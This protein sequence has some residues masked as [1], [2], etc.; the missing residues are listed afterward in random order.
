MDLTDLERSI[1]A[2]EKQWW[3]F[4]GGKESAIRELG[5][6]VTRY[7]QLLVRLVYTERAIAAD[8]ITCRRLREHLERRRAC[9]LA[10]HV[11]G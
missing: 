9:A 11:A 10:W 5:L 4:P 6:S 2:I 7:H 1:I 3:Q 8:P